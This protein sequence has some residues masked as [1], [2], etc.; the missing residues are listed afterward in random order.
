VAYAAGLPVPDQAKATALL[1]EEIIR[2]LE[3]VEL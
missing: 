2:Y 3:D 1:K